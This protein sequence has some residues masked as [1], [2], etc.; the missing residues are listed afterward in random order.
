MFVCMFV[1]IY[2]S[3]NIYRLNEVCYVVYRLNEVYTMYAY[4]AC[5]LYVCLLVCI[6]VCVLVVY[7]SRCLLAILK[8]GTSQSAACNLLDRHYLSDL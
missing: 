5:V 6:I 3:I 1:C 2:V 8:V 7:V 4:N